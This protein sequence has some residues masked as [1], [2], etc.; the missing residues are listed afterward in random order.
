[1]DQKLLR[2]RENKCTQENPPRCTAQC[3]VH[4]DV[5]GMIAA[6]R[7]GDTAAAFKL[8]SK[9]VPFP[10]IISRI[11]EQPCG[12]TCLRSEIDQ[13]VSIRELE[14]FVT[15]QA[16]ESSPRVIVPPRKEQQVAVVGAGLGG[17][18]TARALT[19]KGY[20]VTVFEKSTKLG[21]RLRS[22]PEILLPEAI[23]EAE[24]A[25]FCALPIEIRLG[26]EVTR[27]GETSLNV[28]R[29]KFDAV[30]LDIGRQS[31]SQIVPEMVTD[32]AGIP[33]INAISL[34]TSL[35]KVFAGGSLREGREAYSPIASLSDGRIAA[36]SMDRLLQN[37]SLTAD[38][39][40][41][42]SVETQLYTNI[43]G[44]KTASPIIPEN[45][46]A[47]YTPEEARMEAERCLQCECMECVK[48]CVYLAHYKG[49]PKKYFREIY[50]NLSIVMG[51][52]H[53]NKLI[54]TCSQC[55]LC[56]HI[57][58]NGADTGEITHEARSRMVEKG[59]M[60]PSAHDFAL[61]DMAFSRG[62]AFALC[63]HQP[64]FE[65]SNALFFPGCQLAG[66]SPGSIEKIYPWLCQRLEGGVGLMLN[67]CGAPA[68]WAGKDTLYAET[69]AFIA[70]EWERM[71]KPTVITACPSCFAMF[72]QN[73]PQMPVEM[74]YTVL[75][76]VGL[77]VQTGK[78]I[79]PKRLAIHDSCTT[80]YENTLHD[81][82]RS[83]VTR[84]GHTVEEL[85][86]NRDN[87]SC[88]GF[89]GLMMFANKEVA[90]AVIARRIGESPSD[91]AVYC[92]M[93]RDNF[94]SQGK[95]VYHLLDLIFANDDEQV[96]RKK[97]PDFSQ[98]HENR[99]R[100]KQ[101]ML[102]TLWGD[103]VEMLESA[104]KLDLT[105][106]IRILMEDR[107]ILEE[108]VRQVLMAAEQTG[109]RIR[110]LKTGRFTAY[111]KPGSVT[112]WV[113]YTKTEHSYQIHNT[114]SHRLEIGE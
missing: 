9:S 54:N 76:R 62:D 102:N 113:E 7:K 69:L 19:L 83:L 60:P 104:I 24:F 51:I 40:N 58:P 65:K 53:A 80:R 48:S 97:G 30:F 95:P 50:N 56:A 47:G 13:S 55:G 91:Y 26:T 18:M 73:L 10:G 42:G 89:G 34:E 90:Q 5:R 88:C 22:I 2:E 14:R 99:A 63:R 11:C 12:Q 74:L 49:Y 43:A 29:Q 67:C 105:E 107:R 33:I 85:H 112:Y 94:A 23:I 28:I 109:Q 103:A 46:E 57:C 38:R 75:D 92:A 44:E 32:E 8:Y 71:G 84:L 37:V 110:N 27:E 6:I 87:T 59:K 35:P 61:R 39:S 77:P 4:V 41:E 31:L 111:H 96:Q 81:S 25:L 66:T 108:D 78:G 93:C 114:Y 68:Q 70:L 45:S 100:L 98:R 106:E 82:V 21:G 3:P 79:A 52:H 86:G 16:G 20:R 36:N 101:R 64:G 72:K 15:N 17:L 1:M